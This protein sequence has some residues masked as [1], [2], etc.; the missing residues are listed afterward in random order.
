MWILYVW[1]G[2]IVGISSVCSQP[3]RTTSAAC[4][5]ALSAALP[6]RAPL[7]APVRGWWSMGG[8]LNI[9]GRPNFLPEAYLIEESHEVCP[10][11]ENDPGKSLTPRNPPHSDPVDTC[12]ALRD[13][14]PTLSTPNPRAKNLELGGLRLKQAFGRPVDW[15]RLPLNEYERPQ[16]SLLCLS[17][18]ISD[19]E[20]NKIEPR[21]NLII[22]RQCIQGVH[23]IP[24]I[25]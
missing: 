18:L 13:S 23:G 12:V 2:R 10:T 24:H 5:S 6:P 7:H 3:L 21:S 11:E 1:I 22:P 4:A 9:W 17:I 20:T 25:S 15:G 8:G 16:L 14:L 19:L